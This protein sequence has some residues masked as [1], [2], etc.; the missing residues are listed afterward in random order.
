M[1]KQIKK[2]STKEIEKSMRKVSDWTANAKQ[3]ELQQTFYF[4]SFLAGLAF[5]AKI[6]VH[7]EVSQHHPVIELSYE[8]VKVKLATHDCKGLTIN[9]FKLAERIDGILQ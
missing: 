4:P 8:K 1:T 5:V 6:A 9:D 7:A 3:T 2:L